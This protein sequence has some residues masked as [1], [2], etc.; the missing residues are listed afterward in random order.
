MTIRSRI[1]TDQYRQEHERIFGPP[2]KGPVSARFRPKR[3]RPNDWDVFAW[4]AEAITGIYG[5]R[6]LNPHDAEKH[7]EAD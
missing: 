1:P 3:G 6:L 5:P 4:D 2:K 7:P